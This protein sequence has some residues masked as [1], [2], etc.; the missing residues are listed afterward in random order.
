MRKWGWTEGIG[1]KGVVIRV[2]KG[3]VRVMG[4]EMGFKEGVLVCWKGR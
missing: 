3:G 2:R 1:C 4:K